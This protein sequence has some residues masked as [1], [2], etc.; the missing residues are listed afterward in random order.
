MDRCQKR[1]RH[2]WCAQWSCH[3]QIETNSPV[4]VM[5]YQTHCTSSMD[6]NQDE[7]RA[8]TWTHLKPSNCTCKQTPNSSG[9]QKLKRIEK[10]RR[11]TTDS[12]DSSSILCCRA[13]SRL[14]RAGQISPWNWLQRFYKTIKQ[15]PNDTCIE[16]WK[17]L[18][19]HFL[20]F[21]PYVVVWLKMM[22]LFT[23]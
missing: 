12:D 19:F 20:W 13:T 9:L 17:S 6:F 21:S 3:R 8:R 2:A 5:L 7:S 15:Q 22:Q 23:E 16:S 11:K 1:C 18:R 4:A 10:R 14:S